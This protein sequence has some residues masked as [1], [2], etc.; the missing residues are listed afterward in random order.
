MTKTENRAAARAYAAEK[1]RRFQEE[2]ERAARAADLEALRI[3]RHYLI[4]EAKTR[5]GARDQLITA[6]DDYAGEI[7][8]DRT[9]LHSR[10]ASRGR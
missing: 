4:Y 9:A 5:G 10:P 2:Q 7:T 1:E 8:G 3:I 6:I